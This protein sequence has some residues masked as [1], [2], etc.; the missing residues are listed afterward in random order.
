M[1]AG[2]SA[3]T[4]QTNISLGDRARSEYEEASEWLGIPLSTLLRQVLEE[5]HRSPSFSNLLK[6]VRSGEVATD[7]DRIKLLSSDTNR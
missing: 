4:K 6:R 5:Y 1:Q 2:S 3:V 7:K